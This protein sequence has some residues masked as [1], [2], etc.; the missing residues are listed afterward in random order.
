MG[1]IL[2]RSRARPLSNSLACSLTCFGWARA[3]AL[4]LSSSLPPLIHIYA[5]HSRCTRIYVAWHIALNAYLSEHLLVS[6]LRCCCWCRYY[7]C[8]VFLCTRFWV[9]F[10]YWDVAHTHSAHTRTRTHAHMHTPPNFICSSVHVQCTYTFLCF[11]LFWFVLFSVKRHLH[12]SHQ[13]GHF[14]TSRICIIHSIALGACCVCH[15][16]VGPSKLV[17][18][19]IFHLRKW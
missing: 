17:L 18:L 15:I 7:G 16:S 3:S 1:L 13:M 4:L 19:C 9:S 5:I 14:N 10:I 12:I 8:F 6:F 2:Y 11:V